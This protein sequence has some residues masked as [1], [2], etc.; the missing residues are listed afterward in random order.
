MTKLHSALSPLLDHCPKTLPAEA[1]LDPN[2]FQ[3]EQEAIWH[4]DWVYIGRL[5]DLPE[6]TL[7]RFTVCNQSILIAHG[8]NGQI[9]AFLNVCRH[10]G[11]EMC[12]VEDRTFNGRLITCP[13]HSWAYDIQGHLRSTAF[14]TPTADFDK[15]EYGLFPVAYKVWCGCIFV[16]LAETPPEFSPDVGV[17]ALNSWPMT[18]LVTGHEFETDLACNW[19]I[20]WENYNECLHCP[21]IH[22][23]LS[24]RVPVYRQGVMSANETSG[25]PFDGPVLAE[26]A[27]TWTVDGKT[28]GPEFSD[29]SDDERKTA[30]NFVTVYPNMFVVAHVDYV[31]IVSLQPL[32]AERTKL[33]AEWLF[34]PETISAPGFDLPNVVD[35]ATTVLLEDGAACEMN[36]RGLHSK[37]YRS[38]RLM[39][40]EFDIAKFHDWV[41][42]RM[43]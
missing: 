4:R 17:D 7:R 38:G 12:G 25:T 11:A 24:A 1:Y 23:A 15:T 41:R 8:D 9:S 5:S 19:K 22:P 34:L 40:Q 21:G 31:R 29:L 26:N 43:S 14:A 36:Q 18:E 27:V 10:R 16:S 32:S 2:W 37:G 39:P 13:Y 3:R 35:F 33:K 42:S 30:H 28:C 20:F 6:K